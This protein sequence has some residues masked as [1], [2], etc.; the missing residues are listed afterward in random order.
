[1]IGVYGWWFT[2][3]LFS[4]AKSYYLSYG[5]PRTVDQTM[6]MYGDVEGFFVIKLPL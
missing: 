1:M 5:I 6:Q 3:V 4:G 2:I